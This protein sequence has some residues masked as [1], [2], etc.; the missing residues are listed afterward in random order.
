MLLD[1]RCVLLLFVVCVCLFVVVD[2]FKLDVFVICRLLFL[3]G[4]LLLWCGVRCCLSLIVVLFVAI[5][6]LCVVVCSCVVLSVC[7]CS[8]FGVLCV[9][10]FFVGV[11]QGCSSLLVVRC[12]F[13]AFGVGLCSA[14][15]ILSWRLLVY[16]VVV[17]VLWCVCC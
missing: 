2:C 11:C 17:C 9:V 16:F 14:L 10:V 1:V 15:F 4:G 8:S 5:C 13:I 7:C 3:V 6:W 12:C